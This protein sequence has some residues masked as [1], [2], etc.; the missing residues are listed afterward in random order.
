MGMK[1]NLLF[2]VTITFLLIVSCQRTKETKYPDGVIKSRQE[3]KNGKL[4]GTSTWYYPNG[5]KELEVNYKNEQPDGL[6]TRWYH[7]GNKE[8]L[9]TFSE[10][11]KNGAS[12]KWDLNGKLVEELNY[13]DDSL[14]GEY[15]LYYDNGNVRIEGYFDMGLYDST[16]TYYHSTGLKVGEGIYDKGTG[17]QRAFFPD[18]KVRQTVEYRN[19]KRNGYEVIY[20]KE[21]VVVKKILYKNDIPV[22]QSISK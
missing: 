21:G 14:H 11:K 1:F 2:L 18:G 8:L 17:V 7:N 4:N 16:W 13:R 5:N 19:N 3:Y 10:G 15:L 6:Y 22:S 20:N 9:E 12:R